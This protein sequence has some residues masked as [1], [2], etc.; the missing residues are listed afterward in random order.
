MECSISSEGSYSLVRERDIH[1]Y[2]NEE[3]VLRVM[4]RAEKYSE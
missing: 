4:H 1:T 3:I 2:S